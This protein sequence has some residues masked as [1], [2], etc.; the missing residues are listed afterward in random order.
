MCLSINL[1]FLLREPVTCMCN[2]IDMSIVLRVPSNGDPKLFMLE[3]SLIREDLQGD[4]ENG[5]SYW[6]RTVRRKK[7]AKYKLFKLCLRS[8][9]YICYLKQVTRYKHI[10][11][12]KRCRWCIKKQSG[13]CRDMIFF[14]SATTEK[15]TCSTACMIQP[16]FDAQSLC[17]LHSDCAKT[18]TYA[19]RWSLDDSLAGACCMSTAGN[20]YLLGPG[21]HFSKAQYLIPKLYLQLSCRNV[22]YCDNPLDMY[23]GLTAP[24]SSQNNVENYDRFS[25]YFIAGHI[26]PD[27]S[28]HG[29]CPKK[30]HNSKCTPDLVE[31]NSRVSPTGRLSSASA[32]L[33]IPQ[34]AIYYLNHNKGT[35]RMGILTGSELFGG[36]RLWRTDVYDWLKTR[37]NK[38]AK[39]RHKILRLQNRNTH[40]VN[41]RQDSLN[42][43]KELDKQGDMMRVKNLKCNYMIHYSQTT[44]L[45]HIGTL[46]NHMSQ[47]FSSAQ[48]GPKQLNMMTK[49]FH[50]S[51]IFKGAK[52]Y[53]EVPNVLT[54]LISSL[55]CIMEE[56]HAIVYS[57]HPNPPQFLRSGRK[58]DESWNL[59]WRGH[60]LET[61]C[62][63]GAD[64]M[65][66][67]TPIYNLTS[68]AGLYGAHIDLTQPEQR[69]E[70]FT[71]STTF[72]PHR[73][74]QCAEE[75][76]QQARG[77][78]GKRV[79]L[80]SRV[81][82]K[83]YPGGG[84]GGARISSRKYKCVRVLEIFR[85]TLEVAMVAI[86]M[87]CTGPRPPDGAAAC[88]SFRRWIFVRNVARRQ[89]LPSHRVCS[90]YIILPL[91]ASPSASFILS[92][93][94][95]NHR[96]GSLISKKTLPSHHTSSIPRVSHV[97]QRRLDGKSDYCQLSLLE[98]SRCKERER[99]QGA[100][101]N[102]RD[103]DAIWRDLQGR[104]EDDEQQQQPSQADA[105]AAVQPHRRRRLS[106]AS[107]PKTP[108]VVV[109]DSGLRRGAQL[110]C[111]K[112]FRHVEGRPIP[113]AP[114]SLT[115]L[116][117][118]CFPQ[119]VRL[120]IVVTCSPACSNTLHIIS[121][122]HTQKKRKC[123]MVASAYFLYIEVLAVSCPIHDVDPHPSR[124]AGRRHGPMQ[125]EM[126][127]SIL[128]RHEATTI[129]R[130]PR[131]IPHVFLVSKC[132]GSRCDRGDISQQDIIE[133]SSSLAIPTASATSA[134]QSSLQNININIYIYH[135]QQCA[136]HNRKWKRSVP[137][138]RAV[139]EGWTDRY[140]QRN[141]KNSAFISKVKRVE[142]SQRLK[143]KKKE[144]SL[145]C[146]HVWR[147]GGASLRLFWGQ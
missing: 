66:Q 101:G 48:I 27:R 125:L 41:L 82:L 22:T 86:D 59:S 35:V 109:D 116:H 114:L 88:Q 146:Q 84:S 140:C 139:E 29:V 43:I 123:A 37:L 11:S 45:V 70:L 144:A 103:A 28:M 93:S 112:V 100:A 15:K 55:M 95:S 127:V 63:R 58:L 32:P 94:S 65:T 92:S 54:K 64:K 17:I 117:P 3:D 90:M 25:Q 79:W 99:E 97:F 39:M 26:P 19:S 85:T 78:A 136:H 7:I 119:N 87:I 102:G 49:K 72:G 5:N 122:E 118:A 113:L 115:P 110:L 111:K 80:F 73:W 31:I 20:G 105:D 108:H 74:G 24:G 134:P 8:T 61:G 16:S 98:G 14:C 68:M 13:Q 107:P 142:I 121:Q 124:L 67:W 141:N 36:K 126:L 128:P 60:W 81:S 131:G 137:C 51:F 130:E 46:L 71:V 40:I 147:A 106:A 10:G 34:L 9:A 104:D 18:S 133:A 50:E 21:S 143:C 120:R 47:L 4:S 138:D 62:G 38:S 44:F 57:S 42:S 33:Y 30:V 56:G 129:E 1:V 135:R 69:R 2:A 96:S 77:C 6:I 53:V 52:S 89:D 76:A 132:T 83:T 12:D 91:L 23:I 75:S 145:S